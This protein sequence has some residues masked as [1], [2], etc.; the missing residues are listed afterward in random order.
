MIIRSTQHFLTSRVH[1]LVK[2]VVHAS[3]SIVLTQSGVSCHGATGLGHRGGHQA[4]RRP[5]G[6][7]KGPVD[8]DNHK[9]EL[10]HRQ[11][12]IRELNIYLENHAGPAACA[13]Y[14]KVKC[15]ESS[16]G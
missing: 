9:I 11:A 13:K 2:Y 3:K 6:R 8:T 14:I 15:D 5:A 7:N 1:M 4:A 10:M 16:R 12:G